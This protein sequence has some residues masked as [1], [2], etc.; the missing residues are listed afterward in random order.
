MGK[1]RLAHYDIDVNLLSK[2]SKQRSKRFAYMRSYF[3]RGARAPGAYALYSA[4]LEPIPVSWL[5]GST[6][7]SARDFCPHCKCA[8]SFRISASGD[9]CPHLV[10]TIVPSCTGSWLLSA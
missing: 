10:G 5:Q 7:P 4:R 3:S 1:Q 2:G 9:I 6:V 8:Q